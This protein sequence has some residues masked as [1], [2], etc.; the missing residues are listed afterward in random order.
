MKIPTC[1]LDIILILLIYMIILYSP[2]QK[3]SEEETPKN[4]S[5]F[6]L[7]VTWD[8][9]ANADVDTWAYRV[10]NPDSI[11]GYLRREND[12]FLLHNDNTSMQ[13]GNVDGQI[14]DEARE[15]LSI[16]IIKAGEYIFSLHGYRV[17]LNNPPVEVT[18]EFQKVSPF[19]HIFK[20]KI[21]VENGKEFPFASFV[22]DEDGNVGDLVLD[23]ALIQGF[24]VQ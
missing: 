22:I 10:E 5:E 23:E 1:F 12:V 18:V 19:K 11:T 9:K 14:L 17:P 8:S 21:L 13:Y 24:V 6:I 2:D 7:N 16:E 20:K 15:T 3:K 4:R